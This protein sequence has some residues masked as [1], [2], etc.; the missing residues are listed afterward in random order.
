MAIVALLFTHTQIIEWKGA[1][2][3]FCWKPGNICFVWTNAWETQRA[4][5]SHLCEKS[6]LLLSLFFI[7]LIGNLSTVCE[8]KAW[9]QCLV[10]NHFQTNLFHLFSLFPP[11]SRFL[12][13]PNANRGSRVMT[14]PLLLSC[15]NNAAK[16]RERH[17]ERGM[18]QGKGKRMLGKKNKKWIDL[19]HAHKNHRISSGLDLCFDVDVSVQIRQICLL[20]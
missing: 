8:I 13:P 17:V 6:H 2:E 10:S 7:S 16:I 15:P 4:S 19:I 5:P 3:H 11:H 1:T 12:P 20:L 18:W 14:S 9:N